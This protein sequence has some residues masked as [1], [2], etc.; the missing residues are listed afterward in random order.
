MY[1]QNPSSKRYVKTT[2]VFDSYVRPKK[3]AQGFF[4]DVNAKTES[5]YSL[6]KLLKDFENN[7]CH[8]NGLGVNSSLN[9]GI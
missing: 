3:Y 7:Y 2:S 9:K 4:S 6:R 8:F 5:V 1:D